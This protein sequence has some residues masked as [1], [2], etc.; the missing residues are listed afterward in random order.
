VEKTNWSLLGKRPVPPS[1]SWTYVVLA[2]VIA[3]ETFLEV[4]KSY[5][6][7]MS[8]AVIAGGAYASY[9]GFR[10]KSLFSLAVLPVSLIWLNPLFGGQW[11]VTL[12]PTMFI[13]HSV[14][15]LLF[16]L[17]AYTYTAREKK[18]K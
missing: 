11:F 17:V 8:I 12:N 14:M 3:A 4:Q 6:V 1:P 15:A 2:F 5:P 9:A 18:P 16:G 10:A 7:Y 13:S